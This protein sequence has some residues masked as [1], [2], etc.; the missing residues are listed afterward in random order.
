[1]QMQRYSQN[2]EYG[3]VMRQSK[4]FLVICIIADIASLIFIFGS[5]FI[6]DTNIEIALLIFGTFFVLGIGLTIYA[7]AWR[8]VIEGET[9]TFYCPFLPVKAIKLYEL[10][11]VTYTENRTG[12]YG[13]G[14]KMLTGYRDK[15]KVFEF[16]DDMVGFELF[17]YQLYQLGKIE[18]NELKDEFVL[19]NTKRNMF[20]AVFGVVLFGGMLIAICVTKEIGRKAFYIIF[21]ACATLFYV[22]D[23]IKE[24]LWRVTVSYQT[25]EIRNGYGISKSYFIKDISRVKE[26]S[27]NIVLFVG[28]KKIAK[29]SKDCENF[30]LLQ[31]RL[32]YEKKSS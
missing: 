3:Y 17:Y 5:V 32:D 27:H 24:L 13:T 21:F 2:F 26:E 28:N 19:K 20:S 29:I 10:T 18:K 11:R 6:L 14:K 16:L 30:I 12:G 1:M 31:T 22:D 23:M 7:V 4:E 25:I 15:K 9:M 8:C